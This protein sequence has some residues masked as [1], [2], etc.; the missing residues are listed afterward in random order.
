[1]RWYVLGGDA[2]GRKGQVRP[3][4]LGSRLQGRLSFDEIS[5]CS[6]R[7]A[8]DGPAERQEAPV[9]RACISH[10][11]LLAHTPQGAR[12]PAARRRHGRGTAARSA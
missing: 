11:T 2:K 9:A 7:G 5:L 1:M 12:E 3:A 8:A 10:R 6:G 4:A